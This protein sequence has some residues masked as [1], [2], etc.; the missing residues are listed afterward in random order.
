MGM[1]SVVEAIDKG[2]GADYELQVANMATTISIGMSMMNLQKAFTKLLNQDVDKLTQDGSDPEKAKQLQ[3]DEL[4]YKEDN[5]RMD[6]Q[7]TAFRTLF[8]T[9]KQQ[10]VSDTQA[11]KNIVQVDESVT[12]V[13]STAVN[14]VQQGGKYGK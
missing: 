14:L 3:A 13:Q 6:A 9:S 11:Q 12:S 2:N 4:K 1:I 8:D 7:T 10:V 5:A